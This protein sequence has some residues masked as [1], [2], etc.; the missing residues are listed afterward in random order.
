MHGP[1]QV[2]LSLGPIPEA[3]ADDPEQFGKAHAVKVPIQI[4]TLRH[5]RVLVDGNEIDVVGRP[6]ELLQCLIARGGQRVPRQVIVRDLVPDKHP[7]T[8]KGTMEITLHRLRRRL[9]YKRSIE[10]IHGVLR[11]NRNLA[12]VDAIEL[13]EVLSPLDGDPLQH[14]YA[15]EEIFA[16]AAKALRLYQGDFLASEPLRPWAIATRDRLH[17]KFLRAMTVAGEVLERN[18]Q[19]DKAVE[20]YEVALERDAFAEKLYRRLMVCLRDAGQTAAAIRVYRRCEQNLRAMGAAPCNATLAVYR[21]V[22]RR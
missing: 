10:L 21:S 18:R 20:V 1:V 15:C 4:F 22:I 3:R 19:W 2:M 9:R 7:G 12:W 11:I 6:A 14:T 16:L 5:F 17:H 13:E 8:V